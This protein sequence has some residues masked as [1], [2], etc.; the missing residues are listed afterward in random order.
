M[1]DH[2][3]GGPIL[4]TSSIERWLATTTW[5]KLLQARVAVNTN[6]ITSKHGFSREKISHNCMTYIIEACIARNGKFDVLLPK[7][8]KGK[9]SVLQICA[10]KSRKVSCSGLYI[11]RTIF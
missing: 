1:S 7:K 6:I 4:H 3:Y 8:R 9:Y 5:H 10:Y 11:C 2:E